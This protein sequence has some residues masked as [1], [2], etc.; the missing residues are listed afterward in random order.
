MLLECLSEKTVLR[1]ALWQL[2]EP[3][4]ETDGGSK[5][6]L[7]YINVHNSTLC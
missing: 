3:I 4:K 2:L 6:Q 1:L 5:A 7:K